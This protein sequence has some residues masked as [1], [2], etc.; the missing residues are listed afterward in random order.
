MSVETF[1]FIN[2]LICLI[3]LVSMFTIA[4]AQDSQTPSPAPTMDMSSMNATAMPM[5]DNGDRTIRFAARVGD[6]D[7]AC[8]IT[9]DG[10]GSDKSSI[11]V[12]DFRLY[13]SN[14]RFIDAQKN[15]VPLQL[16]QDG[17]WQYQNVALLDFEDGT[18]PCG[19]GGNEQLRTTV[20]GTV[21]P[22]EY[23]GIVFDLGVPAD[24]DHLDISTAN[25]PLNLDAMWWGWQAG[26]KFLRV[27]LMA[28]GNPY[29]IHLGSTGCVSANETTAPEKP[30]SHSNHVEIRMDG[31]DPSKNFVVADLASLV[32]N[33]TL[34][35]SDPRPPGCMSGT[36]DPDCKSLFPNLGLSL[37]TG[38][39]LEGNVQQFFRMG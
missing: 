16:D 9:Y 10:L 5:A 31:F 26:F 28:N 20:V 1:R 25:S 11:Q 33:I 29:F 27:D 38:G 39:Q 30:C 17:L 35:T 18:G 19:D 23:S 6:K 32:N 36:D 14:V 15:E 13:V 2:R 3:I 4:K 37:D 21:P 8:G 7:F 22:G 12:S 24:L 34:S